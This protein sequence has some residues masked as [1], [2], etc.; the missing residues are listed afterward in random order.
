MKKFVLAL[1]ALLLIGSAAVFAAQGHGHGRG[2]ARGEFGHRMGAHLAKVLDLTES[3]QTAAR[4]IHQEVAEKAKPLREQHRDQM[5]EVHELLDTTN[6]DPT[7]VG[8][9]MIAAHA[10]RDQIKAL[11]EEAMTRFTALLNAEQK[12]KLED[13]R[14]EHEGRFGFGHG[15]GWRF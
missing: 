13:L 14:E 11:H 4:Q 10:T 5:E 7:T 8:Q 1:S 9:K 12:A 2:H 15:P 6:P 3:Q